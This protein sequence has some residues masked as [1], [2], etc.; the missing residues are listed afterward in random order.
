MNTNLT[1][2]YTSLKDK[3]NVAKIEAAKLQAQI[4]ALEKEQAETEEKI[5]S[6]SGVKTLTE[7]IDKQGQLEVKI[8]E[9][10][11]EAETLLKEAVSY[12]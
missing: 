12:E 9:L 7:A 11:D 2:K 6:V 3:L 4:E 5:L 10:I 1:Q 8:K